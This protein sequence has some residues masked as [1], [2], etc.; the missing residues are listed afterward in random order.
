MCFSSQR[1]EAVDGLSPSVEQLSGAWTWAFLA[2]L[3]SMRENKKGTPEPMTPTPEPW[4][5]EP[6]RR[7]RMQPPLLLLV[8][9]CGGCLATPAQGRLSRQTSCRKYHPKYF[10]V[11]YV[12]GHAVRWSCP[13]TDA[14]AFRQYRY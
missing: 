11:Y 4:K 8:A 12:E 6:C 7:T 5:L 14:I 2:D 1:S 13:S 3:P 10:E 9:L